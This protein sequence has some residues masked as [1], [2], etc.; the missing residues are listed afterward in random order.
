VEKAV[1]I[2]TQAHRESRKTQHKISA[3]QLSDAL[4][5]T[6]TKTDQI[7]SSPIKRQPKHSML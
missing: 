1:Y 4:I 2:V 5:R 7:Q 6:Q 3:S